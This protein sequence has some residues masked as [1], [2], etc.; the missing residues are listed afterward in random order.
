MEKHHR[1]KIESSGKKSFE[2]PVMFYSTSNAQMWRVSLRVVSAWGSAKRLW[3]RQNDNSH[4]R[5]YGP[6]SL[7]EFV[8]C[9]GNCKEPSGRMCSCR[10]SFFWWEMQ[11]SCSLCAPAEPGTI[12]HRAVTASPEINHLCSPGSVLLM[13]WCFPAMGTAPV[14]VCTADFLRLSLLKST[15]V[16]GDLRTS[17]RVGWHLLSPEKKNLMLGPSV[18][19][20]VPVVFLFSTLF[21]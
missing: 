20:S 14:P 9:G 11:P 6:C 21:V 8:Q 2:L 1:G 3:Q 15:L 13:L 7:Q 5:Q 19:L 4:L 16:Q 18:S 10:A 12:F 17:F